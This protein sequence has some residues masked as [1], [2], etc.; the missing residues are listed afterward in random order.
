MN[1]R[2]ICGGDAQETIFEE[3]FQQ[4]I[5]KE[6]SQIAARPRHQGCR[7]EETREEEQAHRQES[8]KERQENGE[9]NRQ[10]N[11]E[12]DSKENDEENRGKKAS[13]ES[14]EESDGEGSQS[15][16]T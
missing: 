15:S 9:E 4:A 11:N 13:R 5:R 3:N 14:C 10:K 6:S 16:A 2:G 7:G 12:E 8:Q 1:N